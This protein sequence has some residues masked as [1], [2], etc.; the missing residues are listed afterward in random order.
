MSLKGQCIKTKWVIIGDNQSI[1]KHISHTN[2]FNIPVSIGLTTLAHM[3]N[4]YEI[5]LN[6][7]NYLFFNIWSGGIPTARSGDHFT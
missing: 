1:S 6:T 5:C 3:L 7:S 2:F 4:G